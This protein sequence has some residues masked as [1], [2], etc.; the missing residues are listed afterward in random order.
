MGTQ[1][2]A[3][4]RCVRKSGGGHGWR[5]RDER[6]LCTATTRPHPVD[7]G[8]ASVSPFHR[9]SATPSLWPRGV[10][11]IGT[12]GSVAAALAS[13][14][15]HVWP[16][17]RIVALSYGAALLQ[18]PARWNHSMG[19]RQL[20]VLCQLLFSRPQMTEAD[21]LS[22]FIRVLYPTASAVVAGRDRAAGHCPS[23]A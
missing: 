18:P 4:S 13:W 9:K 10:L 7:A 12:P 15:L 6:G 14:G 2:L 17:H 22:T 11:P 19:L 1:A 16:I 20:D 21:A 23:T 8:A 3:T 5:C